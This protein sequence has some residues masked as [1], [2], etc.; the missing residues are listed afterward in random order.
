MKHPPFLSSLY[1]KIHSL[2][3]IVPAVGVPSSRPTTATPGVAGTDILEV[4][5]ALHRSSLEQEV[6]KSLEF[7]VLSFLFP[8]SPLYV[9]WRT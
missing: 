1:T 3:S 6:H 7:A 8:R 4:A 2:M 9:H 5:G